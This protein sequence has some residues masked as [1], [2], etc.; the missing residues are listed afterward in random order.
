M[1]EDKPTGGDAAIKPLRVLIVGGGVAGLAAAYD[2]AR[3]K[4]T[5]A[6]R[7]T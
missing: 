1:R 7:L 6:G 4:N 2:L 5:R 3:A